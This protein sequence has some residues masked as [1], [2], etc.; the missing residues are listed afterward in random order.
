M[1]DDDRDERGNSIRVL[2]AIPPIGVLLLG[3]AT[4]ALG[5]E[6]DPTGVGGGALL[7]ARKLSLFHAVLG[8]GALVFVLAL[9]VAGRGRLHAR[10]LEA[11][12]LAAM[13]ATGL[14]GLIVG[15]IL[16]WLHVVSAFP[17]YAA[18]FVSTAVLVLYCVIAL[19]RPASRAA[20]TPS[21]PPP[22]PR[23]R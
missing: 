17:V 21:G 18:N 10:T 11:L 8:A 7:L 5:L 20:P 16:A 14:Y 3:L 2:Y 1:S 9:S 19:L 4:G 22:D 12:R 23:D 6:G 15:Y 13:G